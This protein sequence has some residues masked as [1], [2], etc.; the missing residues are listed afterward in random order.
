M[1]RW[2][3]S[4]QPLQRYSEACYRIRVQGRISGRWADWFENMHISVGD[5]CHD[6]ETTLAGHVA[7]QAALLG[8]LGKLVTLNYPLLL[9][10]HIPDNASMDPHSDE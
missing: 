7:D 2:D 1:D 10:E 8:I 4:N 6:H 5:I 3:I 9:V